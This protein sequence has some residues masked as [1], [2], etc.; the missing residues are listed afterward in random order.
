MIKV[1]I[2]DN[3]FKVFKKIKELE[4]KL[5]VL[6]KQYMKELAMEVVLNSPVD[7]GTYM[8]HHNIGEV[9]EPVNSHG[10]PHNQPFQTHADAAAERMFEQID[11]LPKDTTRYYIS[12]SAMYAQKVEDYHL[13]Y[14]KAKQESNV[15]LEIAKGKVGIE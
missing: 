3:R 12:N 7:T 10:K 1:K 9:G 14:A 15:L 4:E 5:E 13:V 6:P 11:A 8:D 2:L